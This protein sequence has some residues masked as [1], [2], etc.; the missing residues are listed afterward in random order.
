M[1]M[2]HIGPKFE[3]IHASMVSGC[4]CSLHIVLAM[5]VALSVQSD[6]NKT[7]LL[8]FLCAKSASFAAFAVA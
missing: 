2:E 8:G 4:G 7:I 5:S 6:T 3:A 1:H